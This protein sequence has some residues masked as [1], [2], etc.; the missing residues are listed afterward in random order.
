MKKSPSLSTLSIGQVAKLA[1]VGIE[2][3]RFYEREG[4]IKEPP[5]RDS[6]YRMYDPEIIGRLRFIKRAQELGF[7]LKEIAEMLSLRVKPNQNCEWVKKKA[8]SKL[9]EIGR[10]IADL[11]RM[12]KILTEVTEACVASKPVADCPILLAFDTP[13]KR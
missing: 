12:Q 10:K 1:G 2:T 3:I 9:E 5:R 6:G 11:K 7:S 4:I 13:S 8:E